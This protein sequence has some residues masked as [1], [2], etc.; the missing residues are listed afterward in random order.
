MKRTSVSLYHL[1]IS[2][3]APPPDGDQVAAECSR[4]SQ[5][6]S[7]EGP[8]DPTAHSENYFTQKNNNNQSC[9]HRNADLASEHNLTDGA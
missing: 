5:V 3:S 6:T 2:L 8:D 7:S 9:D 4:S 1:C